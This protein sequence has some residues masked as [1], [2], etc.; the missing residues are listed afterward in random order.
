MTS[1]TLGINLG[2][3]TNRWPEPDV[4]ARLVREEMG[5]R[6]VQL[7]ADLLNPFWPDDVLDCEVERVLEATQRYGVAIH[8][9]MTSTYTRVNHLMHP[10]G[11]E[12]RLSTG[13]AA[14]STWGRA[15]RVGWQPLCPVDGRSGRRQAAPATRAVRSW[16]AL[17]RM[18]PMPASSTCSMR[19]CPS[20]ARWPHRQPG[21]R[22]WA[23]VNEV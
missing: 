8:S 7:V 12:A 11:A 16:Q 22:A 23:R 3:A 20:R 2:F 5:L 18:R 4:W 1:F 21:A 15:R 19:P 17:T 10:C 6:S 9:L 14:S 13:S